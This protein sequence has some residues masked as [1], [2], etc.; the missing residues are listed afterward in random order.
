[1]AKIYLSDMRFYAYHGCFEEE[2]IVGTHFSVDCVLETDCKE[3]AEQDNLG[4]TVNYQDI[5]SLIAQEMKQPSSILEHVAYRIINLLH[6]HFPT[7]AKVN[8]SIHKLNPSLGGKIGKVSVELSTEDV[9]LLNTDQHPPT[10]LPS[11]RADVLVSF[12]SAKG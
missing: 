8:I 7:V 12:V 4:K 2:R 11:G 5:Y 1:M 3:A 9:F 6:R 10:L